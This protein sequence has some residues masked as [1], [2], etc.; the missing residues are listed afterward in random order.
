M[1][2][3]VFWRM[4]IYAGSAILAAPP[5][6]PE[7][8]LVGSDRVSLRW[9][10]PLSSGGFAVRGYRVQAQAGGDGGFKDVIVDT[11]DAN[12][13]GVVTRLTCT[14]WYEFRV[15][16]INV[17]G[18][19]AWSEACEP[20]LTGAD[21]SGKPAR[22]RQRRTRQTGGPKAAAARAQVEEARA[23]LRTYADQLSLSERTVQQWEDDWLVQH[24]ARMLKAPSWWPA[25]RP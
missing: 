15:A 6:S 12:P 5:A 22:R 8:I 19:G 11:Q 1:F 21:A 20:V 14:T 13:G 25:A 16:A 9:I 2:F 10:A 18:I 4:V 7:T 24:A 17:N 3:G 23:K